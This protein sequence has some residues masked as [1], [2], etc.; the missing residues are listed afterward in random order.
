MFVWGVCLFV[1][2]FAALFVCL[3]VFLLLFWG[4]NILAKSEPY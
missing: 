2:V 3:L 1:G 4:D